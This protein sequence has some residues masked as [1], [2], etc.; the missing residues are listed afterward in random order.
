[1]SREKLKILKLYLSDLIHN[2]IIRDH[3][4]GLEQTLM[5]VFTIHLLSSPDTIASDTYL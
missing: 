3:Y 1:M 5:I 2:Y 4:L